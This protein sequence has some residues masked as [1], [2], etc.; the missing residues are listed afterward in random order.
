MSTIVG[1]SFREIGFPGW[2]AG[3]LPDDIR[4][5]PRPSVFKKVSSRFC[6]QAQPCRD[7]R[8]SED[9]SLPVC[10]HP[11]SKGYRSKRCCSLTLYDFPL[12]KIP[13]PDFVSGAE[14]K[15]RLSFIFCLIF[16][17]DHMCSSDTVHGAQSIVLQACSSG[18]FALL[19]SNF[20]A[21]YL[22]DGS[23]GKEYLVGCSSQW[24]CLILS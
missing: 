14:V 9:T 20:K 7:Y 19:Y 22:R 17:S 23:G 3:I 6:I 12:G 21:A 15:K 10:R 11:S 5:E 24:D 2:I 16:S 13:I 18:F 4:R 8:Q 1:F